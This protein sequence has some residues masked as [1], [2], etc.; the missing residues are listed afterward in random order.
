MRAARKLSG[1]PHS[2]GT[3]CQRGNCARE[4][5]RYNLTSVLS[6]Q[7]ALLF[8]LAIAASALPA[9]A[10]RTRYTPSFGAGGKPEVSVIHNSTFDFD[11]TLEE[12]SCFPWKLSPARSTTVSVKKLK[13]PSKAQ[14]EYE[15]AC[16]ASH[17]NKFEEAEQHARGAIGNFQD[18]SAAWVLLGVILEEQHKGQ[19]A[20]DACSHAAA[21]D[22]TYVPAYLCEAEVSARNREWEQVLN[23]ADLA[24]GL[25]SEGD[26]YPYYY[27][28][29]AYLHMNNP[30]EAKKS[31]LQA[32]ETDKH[33]DEPL[34]NFLLAEIYDRQGDSADAIAQLQQFLKHPSDRPREELA[35]QRLIRLEAQSSTK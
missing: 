6:G 28:A 7:R 11:L 10:Q 19:E 16:D 29:M 22:A 32:V 25:K 27:R 21:I 17:K 1:R 26:P 15:K 20:R 4:R 24:V 14:G 5:N 33:H 12:E 3:N 18:Y 31:G 9:F 23:S 34:L 30:V 35:K 2:S 8:A 13:I